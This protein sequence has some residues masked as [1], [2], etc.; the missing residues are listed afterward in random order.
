MAINLSANTQTTGPVSQEVFDP[1]IGFKSGLEGLARGIGQ[2]GDAAGKLAQKIHTKN[3]NANKQLAA[4]NFKVLDTQMRLDFSNLETLKKDPNSTKE[5]IADALAATERYKEF[6]YSLIDPESEVSEDYYTNYTP[7][8]QASYEAHK[9]SYDVTVQTQNQLKAVTQRREEIN[10]YDSALTGVPSADSY[11]SQVDEIVVS[12]TSEKDPIFALNNPDTQHKDLFSDLNETLTTTISRLSEITNTKQQEAELLKIQDSLSALSGTGNARAQKSADTA[13]TAVKTALKTL[14][15]EGSKERK[16]ANKVQDAQLA[17][18]AKLFS[19]QIQTDPVT[20]AVAGKVADQ[21][22]FGAVFA[23]MSEDASDTDIATQNKAVADLAAARVADNGN[24]YIGNAIQDS[25]AGEEFK[26]LPDEAYILRSADGQ[27]V[28]WDRTELQKDVDTFNLHNKKV[29]EGKREFEEGITN[30]DFSVLAKIDPFFAKQWKLLHSTKDEGVRSMAWSRLSQIVDQYRNNPDFVEVFR[31]ARAFGILPED[32]GTSFSSMDKDGK[33]EYIK[34]MRK[35]NGHGSYA[36]SQNLQNSNS[37]DQ[38]LG[39]M[40]A[41]ELDGLSEEALEYASIGTS[42]Y[43]GASFTMTDADG[44][45]SLQSASVNEF[46]KSLRLRGLETPL[47]AHMIS[48]ERQGNREL[49]MFYDVIERGQI[50]K[51]IHAKRDGTTMD[52]YNLV[53][54]MQDGFVKSLG[55]KIFTENDTIISMPAFDPSNE[56]HRNVLR[57]FERADFFTG[58]MANQYG[59]AVSNLLVESLLELEV[60]TTLLLEMVV[61]AGGNPALQEALSGMSIDNMEEAKKL[62][63]GLSSS[64]ATGGLPYVDYSDITTENG[65]DY[66]IPR[67]KK[68]KS[69]KYEPFEYTDGSGATKILKLPL[70]GAHRKVAEQVQTNVD[71]NKKYFDWIRTLYPYTL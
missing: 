70:N 43:G 35:L 71:F 31:G 32:N 55:N 56:L 8:L 47:D 68:G 27:R 34:E 44:E 16:N 62:A 67:F 15:V 53:L 17:Q 59:E 29:E 21:K 65:V 41:L 19:D 48:A 33:L 51:A 5:A 22:G 57:H 42:I 18:D 9:A 46:Y 69:T 50:A 66:I 26:E 1:N 61:A 20:G 60:P 58:G 10:K 54:D 36:F 6:N 64:T 63:R 7:V 49:S 52:V 4:T 24:T 39:V 13:L 45:V 2:A 25:Y 3:D 11:V 37:S 14:G 30:N 38:T 12:L 28:V 40:L 23:P